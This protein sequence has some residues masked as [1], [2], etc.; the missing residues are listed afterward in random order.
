LRL[1]EATKDQSDFVRMR[2]KQRQVVEGEFVLPEGFSPSSVIVEAKPLE[3][4]RYQ[5]ATR[6]FD[7]KLSDG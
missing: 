2:F 7:W 5:S 4:E 3:E 6:T 1:R